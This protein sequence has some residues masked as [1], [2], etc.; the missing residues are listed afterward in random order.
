MMERTHV[1]TLM[2]QLTWLALLAGALSVGVSSCTTEAYCFV[3]E[4]DSFGGAGESSTKSTTATST[5]SITPAVGGS[6]GTGGDGGGS[7]ENGV[8][9]EGGCTAD[10]ETDP[11]NCGACNIQCRINGALPKCVNGQCTWDECVPG[12][13]DFND[14]P[15]D[16]CEGVCSVTNDGEEICD[17]VD[18]DC[19][20]VVDDGFDLTTTENCGSCGTVCILANAD[21]ACENVGGTYRCVI[22]E[23]AENWF[24]FDGLDD[25]GCE[26][27]CIESNDGQE[28]CDGK[29]NDCDGFV[30]EEAPGVGEPCHDPSLCP[31]HPSGDCVGQCADRGIFVCSGNQMLCVAKPN[32][33]T[34]GLEVCDEAGL[35]ENCDGQANELFDLQTDVFNCGGCGNAC[36]V[37]NAFPACINGLC[38]V[39]TCMDGFNDLDPTTPGCEYACPESVNEEKCDGV[40][41][42]CDGLIDEVADLDTPTTPCLQT[43]PCAGAQW[44]CG[45]NPMSGN[46]EWYCNYQE[47]NANIEVDPTTIWPG[48]EL[49]CDTFDNNCDGYIDEGMGRYQFCTAAN[50]CTRGCNRGRCTCIDDTECDFGYAC[51]GSHC[52]AQCFDGVGACEDTALVQCAG[53]EDGIVCP[54]QAVTANADDETCD[55][56]DNN[57][58]GQIDETTPAAGNAFSGVADSVVFIENGS[59]DFYIYQYEASRPD[60]VSDDSGISDSRSCA[61]A[62]VLPWTSVTQAEAAAA[63]SA[64]GM[65]LCTQTQWELACRAGATGDAWSFGT[66]PTTY[67]NDVCND[68]EHTANAVTPAVWTTGSGAQCFTN[69]AQGDIFDLSGNV[70]EWTSTPVVSNGNTY[71]RVRGGNYTSYGP[72]TACGF[73]FVL[74]VPTFANADLG[75]RC[76]GA[77]PPNIP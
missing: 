31:W 32:A 20:G 38:E 61:K 69:S 22:G 4:D 41:N 9:G 68:V 24:D 12:R 30:D 53:D 40:D 18:N 72:A 63:C 11:L 51:N 50:Q 57:C 25:T 49:A 21:P 48:P 59:S 43:G 44:L 14:D 46:L 62:G 76:C 23:C 55:G 19:N 35:D 42:D 36:D 3:C 34:P 66:N 70:S 6:Q 73:S 2:R 29:D 47:I 17:D 10:L 75:F 58:D 74:D 71:Y 1:K 39:G 65:Q 27:Q 54:A 67:R 5:T 64:A 60:S 26:K 77:N 13:H 56:L 8:G 37:P 33:P 28:I 52:V 7:G 16:G 15:L 45:T